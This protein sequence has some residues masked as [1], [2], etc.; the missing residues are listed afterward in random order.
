L[1][2]WH[3]EAAL[4]DSTACMRRA[5]KRREGDG[6]TVAGKSKPEYKEALF[7]IAI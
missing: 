7:E 6:R 4:I 2:L 1:G 3:F 5:Q